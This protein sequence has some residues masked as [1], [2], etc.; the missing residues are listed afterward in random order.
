MQWTEC[1]RRN[2][3]RDEPVVEGGGPPRADERVRDE[4]SGVASSCGGRGPVRSMVGQV[5]QWS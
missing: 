2:G 4:M 1:S 3:R 5:L